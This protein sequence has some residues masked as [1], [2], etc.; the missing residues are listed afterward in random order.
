[1]PTVS[2][3]VPVYNAE[4]YLGWCINSILKQSFRDIEV[5][6]VNDGSTDGSLEIC[7]R[8]AAL[9]SRVRMLDCPNGGV[10][11]ARN[12][13]LEAAQGE[14]VQFVD[15][16]DVVD[17]DYTA[18]LL[19]TLQ[20]YKADCVICGISVET[21]GQDGQISSASFDCRLFGTEC[22][23]EGRSLF[24][25]LPFLLWT[26]CTI[27]PP[28]NRIFRRSLLQQGEPLRFAQGIHYGEDLLFNI[29]YLDRCNTVAF[30]QKT[31]YHYML[32]PGESLARK[33]VPNLYANQKLQ[34][35]ALRELLKSHEIENEKSWRYLADYEVG[36]VLKSM[37]SLIH[38]QCTLSEDE[39]KQQLAVVVQDELVQ[40]AFANYDYINPEYQFIPE[41][42]HNCDVGGILDEIVQIKNGKRQPPPP[43]PRPGFVNRMLVKLFGGLERLFKKGPVH[44]WARIMRLNLETM[45]L[46]ITIRRML[47][48]VTGRSAQG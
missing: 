43:P 44:K 38:P 30:L 27:E 10:S 31:L 29:G 36:Q 35:V 40:E 34:I 11:A 28:Y 20:L 6:L 26:S 37:M 46:K 16:D 3:I 48:K 17:D 8:Y 41:M 13:G 25:N 33:Y 2:I 14:F 21:M 1:M 42:V 47:G 7:H 22:V 45:G 18:T 12:A 23:L 32:W 24:E 19:K 9:D 4:K 39:K 5:I 15:S